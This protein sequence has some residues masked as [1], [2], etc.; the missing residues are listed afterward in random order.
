MSKE[1]K[2]TV[3]ELEPNTFHP[4]VKADFKGLKNYWW[5]IDSGASKSVMEITLMDHYLREETEA[6]M[7]TGL[8]KEEVSTSSGIVGDL[9]LDGF[10]FGPLKVALVDFQ[11]IN[12]EYSKFSEKKIIGLIGCDF[13]Y[14]H[15][16]V[17]DFKRCRVL[18]RKF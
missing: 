11:H 4:L 6:V 14:E 8:G 13:L 12:T 2:F 3:I 17:I 7:A 10:S 18:L 16:A 5:V 1:I 9:K 15:K